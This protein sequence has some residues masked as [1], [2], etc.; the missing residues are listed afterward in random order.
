[1]QFLLDK[2]C[3]LKKEATSIPSSGN[4]NLLKEI[5]KKFKNGMLTAIGIVRTIL[6]N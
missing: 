4:L 1:M 2:I 3:T 6:G 5:G